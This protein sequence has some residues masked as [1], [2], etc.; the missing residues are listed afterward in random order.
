MNLWFLCLKVD[1]IDADVVDLSLALGTA[2]VSFVVVGTVL[3]SLVLFKL[4]LCTLVTADVVVVAIVS[5]TSVGLLVP[6]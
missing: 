4:V 6:F 2:L 3:C 5:I 1:W